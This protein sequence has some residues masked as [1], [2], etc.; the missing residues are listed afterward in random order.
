LPPS[1]PSRPPPIGVTAD[2]GPAQ[3]GRGGRPQ[4]PFASA[5]SAVDGSLRPVQTPTPLSQA[6]GLGIDES[7]SKEDEK[8]LVKAVKVIGGVVQ[9]RM[10]P[11]EEI[12]RADVSTIALLRASA[13]CCPRSGRNP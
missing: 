9:R 4:P 8:A 5:P 13:S 1:S 7:F 6:F 10:Q 11:G 2:R 12:E 3:P